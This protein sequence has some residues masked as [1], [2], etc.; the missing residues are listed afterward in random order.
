MGTLAKRLGQL[1]IRSFESESSNI[2]QKGQANK[3]GL[4]KM[5]D[6]TLKTSH[7]MRIFGLGT[8]ASMAAS[9]P[10]LRAYSPALRAPPTSLAAETPWARCLAKPTSARA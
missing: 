9:A 7:D 10:A 5:L 6:T 3:H 2:I 8:A 1:A 4:A